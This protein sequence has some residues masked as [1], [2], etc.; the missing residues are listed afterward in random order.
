M[1]DTQTATTPFWRFS[2]KFYGQTRRVRR[3]HRL[4]RRLR[5]GRQSAAVFVLAGVGAAGAL[6]GRSEKARCHDQK[7]AR[8]HHHSDP[9]YAPQAQGR[10]DLRRSCQAGSATRQGQGGR[11]RG[12]EAAAGSALRLHPVRPARQAVR[13]AGGGARQCRR[14]RARDGRKLSQRLRSTS[15][16]APSTALPGAEP[17]WN[18]APPRGTTRRHKK[19]GQE[20]PKPLRGSLSAYRERRV[21][22]MACGSWKCCARPTSRPIWS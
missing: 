8:A 9:R 20:W 19:R 4:A 13:A 7:L 14:F 10:Q 21:R 17:Y 22:F 16:S 5:H 15:W 1:N 11:A 18:R 3:L 12:G 2:L 6:G